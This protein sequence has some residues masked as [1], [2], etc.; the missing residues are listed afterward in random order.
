LREQWRNMSPEER[1]A[2]RR[3]LRKEYGGPQPQPGPGGPIPHNGPPRQ[4][5]SRPHP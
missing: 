5:P 1:R 3:Q 4:R 2:F